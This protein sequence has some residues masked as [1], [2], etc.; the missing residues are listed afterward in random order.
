MLVLGVES[1]CDETAVSLVEDGVVLSSVIRSQVER[2]A[3][4]G[5]VVPDIAARMH[6]EAVGYVAEEAFAAACR[7]PEQ[8]DLVAGTVAPGL[9]NCLVVGLSWARAF[10]VARDLPFIAID[11]LE[12]HIHSCLMAPPG[13][14]ANPDVVELPMVALLVS[15]GHT[16]IYRYGGPGQLQRLG[17]TVDDAAGEA[18][19]KVA[20][21]LGLSY[22]GGPAIQKAAEGGDPRAFDFPRAKTKSGRFDFSFSGLKTAVLY[23]TRGQNRKR[24]APLL[25]DLNVADVAASFQEAVCDVLV[26]HAVKA[27]LEE[28]V[29]TLALCGGVACNTRLRELASKR[30]GNQGLDVVLAAPAYCT[31]NGAMIA[32]LGYARASAGLGPDPADL[33]SPAQSRSEVTS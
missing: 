20:V 1:S 29:A 11:H 22:P 17:R 3:P 5:G 10:A 30:G 19:D 6:I 8:V 31:D 25:P 4:F 32:G 14:K 28:G 33:A 26:T 12:A 18:F 27:A 2:H 13:E 16:A 7:T 15:G 21:L 9:V 24:E 23:A